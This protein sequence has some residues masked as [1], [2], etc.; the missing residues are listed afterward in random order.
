MSNDPYFGVIVGR[1]A[2]RI[3]DATFSID[4]KEHKVACN[5]NDGNCLHGGVEGLGRK[6]WDACGAVTPEGASVT[7]TYHSPDGG[8]LW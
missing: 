4:G 7:L 5:Q 1:C 8:E 6:V 2:N 3:A